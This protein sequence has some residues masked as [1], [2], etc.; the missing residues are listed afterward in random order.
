M[1]SSGL[2]AEC[3]L[4]G[5]PLSN[6]SRLA[7]K[8]CSYSATSSEPPELAIERALIDSNDGDTWR[9]ACKRLEKECER[10]DAQIGQKDVQLAAMVAAI[11]AMNAAPQSPGSESTGSAGEGEASPTG[12]P[13]S[14]S[15]PS[16]TAAGAAPCICPETMI[17]RHCQRCGG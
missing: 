5:I 4:E 14:P 17:D 16:A 11:N 10:L 7:E 6:N 12:E 8:H 1:D 2:Q 3:G 13:L 9:D 15:R